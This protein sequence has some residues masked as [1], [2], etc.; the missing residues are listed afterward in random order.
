M[1][2]TKIHLLCQRSCPAS[3][4]A[5]EIRKL[6][7]NVDLDDNVFFSAFRWGLQDD[8]KD[9]F[10]NLPDSLTLAKTIP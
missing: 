2:T 10:L 9:L 4:Y 1:A 6:T 5:I 7:Y 3:V 8:I